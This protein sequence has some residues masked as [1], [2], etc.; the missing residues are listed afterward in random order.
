MHYY[1]LSN[2]KEVKKV[3]NKRTTI[4]EVRRTICLRFLTEE[5]RIFTIRLGCASAKLAGEEGAA[6]VKRVMKGILEYDVFTVKL[7]KAVSAELVERRTL[8][9]RE[10]FQIGEERAETELAPM[11]GAFGGVIQKRHAG[12][13]H[14]F[15]ATI[16]S[17]RNAAGYYRFY[18]QVI[19]PKIPTVQ[20]APFS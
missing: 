9:T 19:I 4:K 5:G 12:S 10:D 7:V 6:L 20:T 13:Y 3:A 16:D 2:K 1:L 18:A 11:A 14:G 15:P 8:L 17:K